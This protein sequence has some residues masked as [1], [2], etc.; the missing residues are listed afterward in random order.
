[1]LQDT[2]LFRAPIWQNIAYGIPETSRDEIIRSAKLANA[3]E[4]IVRMPRGY[5]TMVG[6]RGMTLSGGQRQ[7]IAIARAIIRNAP[8]LILDEPTSGLDAAAEEKVIEA[9]DRLMEGRTVLI[10]SH[11][12]RLIQRADLILVLRDGRIIERGTHEELLERA[13]LYSEF[14]EIQFRK[15]EAGEVLPGV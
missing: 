2:L 3:H 8:I 14:H 4:F 6:E 13:G 10:I 1:V 5:D 15:E 12:L 9:L 11:R 7:R